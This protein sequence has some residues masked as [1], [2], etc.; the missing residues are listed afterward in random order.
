MTQ[1]I[2]GWDGMSETIIIFVIDLPFVH[3]VD[4]TFMVT[5]TVHKHIQLNPFPYSLI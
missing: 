1:G 3:N 2:Y 4:Q 5:L